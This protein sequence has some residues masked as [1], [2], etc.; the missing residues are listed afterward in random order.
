[1]KKINKLFLTAGIILVSLTLNSC[2]PFDDLYVTLAME[3]E[4]DTI[5][6][7]SSIS[8][9]N[10]LCLSDFSDYE[11]N[12][13]NLEEIRY[14]TSAYFT[15]NA[16]QGLRGDNLTLK[17]YQGNGSTI[18]FQFVVPVFIANDYVN[19]PLEILLTQQETDNINSYLVNP[20]EDK[21]FVATLEISNVQPSNSAYELHSKLEFL[22]EL[23]I[24]P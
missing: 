21:C 24:K 17:L 7:G 18:L 12:K 10:N 22:T 6:A 15:I 2:D 1:M 14:V 9:T 13:N 8:L 20:Q 4:F 5:G 16:T 19:N 3:T 11:D 23:K